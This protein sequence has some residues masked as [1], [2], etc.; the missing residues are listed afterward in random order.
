MVNEL[1]NLQ[2]FLN[3]LAEFS[4]DTAI[5]AIFDTISQVEV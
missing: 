4:S 3:I 5:K 1:A 2:S